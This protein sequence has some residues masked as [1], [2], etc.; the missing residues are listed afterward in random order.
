M[1]KSVLL[2]ASALVI[3]LASCTKEE[4][5]ETI[6]PNEKTI[7]LLV[8]GN[9][10]GGNFTLFSFEEGKAVSTADSNSRK[11]DFGLRFETFI[12]NSESSGPGNAYAQVVNTPFPLVTS[13]ALSGYKQDTT[14][15]QRAIKGSDW[16]IYNNTTRQFSPITGKTFLFVTAANPKYAKM[17]ILRVD[18]AD[19]NG[20]L[21]RPPV[22]PTKI[23]YTIR[24]NY[25][26][27]GTPN[28]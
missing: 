23:K 10:T 18:P 25:Q 20:N 27:N 28:F 12:V 24:Y 2:C 13:G 17:E 9:P 21:V 7:E 19:D 8:N 22:R 11:W 1:K 26:K 16:Y 3:F 14:A 4:T 6:N 5:A 15:A